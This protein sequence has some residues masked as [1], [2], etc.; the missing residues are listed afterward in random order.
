M[1]LGPF[2]TRRRLL[3]LLP[4]GQ[5]PLHDLRGD[6]RQVLQRAKK[7]ATDLALR[8]SRRLLLH[9]I[10]K[11]TGGLILF[12]LAAIRLLV[13][14]LLAVVALAGE[15]LRAFASS[16]SA[17]TGWLAAFGTSLFLRSVPA[18]P[19]QVTRLAADVA[20]SAVLGAAFLATFLAALLAESA[21]IHCRRSTQRTLRHEDLDH[22]GPEN[23][24][25]GEP[26]RVHH[27]VL[28]HRAFLG[29]RL[30]DD[31]D[32]ERVVQH[33]AGAG[34]PLLD[35][36]FPSFERAVEVVHVERV[37]QDRLQHPR[38]SGWLLALVLRRQESPE[39]EA[40]TM[41][42][43]RHLVLRAAFE[44]HYQDKVK[45]GRPLLIGL[46]QR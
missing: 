19:C 43:A 29:H 36:P 16:L 46:I 20:C 22:L 1:D 5:L 41:A 11:P 23:R 26:R 25:G 30:D 42:H 40:R 10:H 39:L 21:H 13:P 44:K 32:L 35:L 6:G 9:G 45:L 27:Q 2:R 12:L 18:I 14:Y 33:L 4:S 37:A 24:V 31:A 3:P 38:L 34:L 8:L 7:E 28:R 15:R 17:T